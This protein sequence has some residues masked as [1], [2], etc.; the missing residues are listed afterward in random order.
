MKWTEILLAI[1]AVLTALNAGL[2]FAWSISVMTGLA[3]VSDKV[4]IS[5]MQSAN[6]AIQNPVFLTVFFGTQL[7][8]PVSTLLNADIK[9]RFWLLLAATIFY[10]IGVTAVTI[11]GN[12]PLNNRLEKFNL[13]K[14]S[15]EEITSQRKIFERRWTSLNNL[16]TL[17]SFFSIVLIIFACFN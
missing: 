12:V 14:A 9:S 16:R 8:L 5:F 17:F 6:R 15:A 3:G 4:F 7:L 10:T 1:T 2:F 11:F 13:E